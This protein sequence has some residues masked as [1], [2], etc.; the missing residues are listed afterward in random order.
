MKITFLAPASTLALAM[1][2]GA[3][4]R[5]PPTITAA[6]N[7]PDPIILLVPVQITD[8][9]LQSGGWTQFFRSATCRATW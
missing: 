7:R 3:C 2:L 6:V 5:T 9:A 4:S 1:T 8:P